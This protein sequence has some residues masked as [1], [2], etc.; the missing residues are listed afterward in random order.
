MSSH[1]MSRSSGLWDSVVATLSVQI[2]KVSRFF[3]D[4]MPLRA[5]L[6]IASVIVG[7]C[8]LFLY[9]LYLSLATLDLRW[10]FLVALTFVA[11]S[12][13][14]E[15]PLVKG[16][17]Q[18]LAISMGDAFIFTS[19]LLFG[20][21]AAVIVAI[22]EGQTANSRAKIRRLYKRLFNVFQLAVVTFIVG[23]IFYA[24]EGKAAPLDPIQVEDPGRLFVEVGLC[25]L[26]YFALNTGSVA[27]AMA[28]VSKRSFLKV[29]KENFV[30]AWATYFAGGFLG[31]IV[32]LCFK[33]VRFYFLTIAFGLGRE[34]GI[35][36]ARQIFKR[37]PHALIFNRHFDILPI[38]QI[39]YGVGGVH[40]NI[41][42]TKG[43]KAPIR[44]GLLGIDD[45]IADHLADLSF[46][47][48]DRPQMVGNLEIVSHFRAPEGE[49]GRF[50][51][52]YC[53]GGG[54]LD[55]GSSFSK[56]E[57]LLVQTSSPLGRFLDAG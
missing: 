56:G 36:K 7:G 52:E 38:G 9:C 13:S 15:I 32:F 43:Q 11:S 3:D 26:I 27:L 28:L 57:Q 10:L 2:N 35:K 45:Q 25:A 51:H 29:W 4:T 37:H 41:F 54:P 42:C 34:V 20:P 48:L 46:I 23:Q 49:N 33:E 22:I 31:A 14:L 5:K 19:I 24:L 30:W 21:E 18:T 53:N 16:K 6:Y 44:H 40:F 1:N 17:P 55:R 39:G 47:N 12:F 50:L 8:V